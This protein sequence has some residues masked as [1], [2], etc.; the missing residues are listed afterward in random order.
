MTLATM[1]S[2]LARGA[3]L[4]AAVIAV[5]TGFPAHADP[6]TVVEL[7]TSQGCNSCPPAN[8]NLA[9][10][11]DRPGILA[12][13][14]SVTYWDKLG[15]K[16]IFGD[17]KYTDRQVDY[18]RPLGNDSP[19]TPQMVINGRAD[20]VGNRLAS[21]ESLIRESG[22]TGTIDAHIDGAKVS[23]GKGDAPAGGADVW[24]VRYNPKL[25]EVAISRGENSGK[26]LPHKNVVH[27]LR[28]LG[29]WSGKAEGFA[30][31]ATKAGLQT[32]VLVQ[33]K[34]GGPILAAATN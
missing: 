11:S 29:T 5:A 3:L 14:Y 4:R 16:D 33:A 10:I 18:V 20:I 7:F 8:D 32:A 34:N 24:L 23:I 1:L 12:L 2:N 13:S 21:L 15:W 6:L 31:P 27:D 26:T 17:P 25:V 9:T 19:F 28:R 30:L 22:T